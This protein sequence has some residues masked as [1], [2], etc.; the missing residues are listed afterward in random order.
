VHEARMPHLDDQS[1]PTYVR[2]LTVG[3]VRRPVA[4]KTSARILTSASAVWGLRPR[5]EPRD[6]GQALHRRP[7]PGWHTCGGFPETPGPS[8]TDKATPSTCL[9]RPRV[10]PCQRIGDWDAFHASPAISGTLDAIW[11]AVFPVGWDWRVWD[12]AATGRR[13]WRAIVDYAHGSDLR[14]RLDEVTTILVTD[15]DD[16]EC[17][18]TL[19]IN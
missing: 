12:V 15:C 13:N 5:S 2:H 10:R 4:D 16:A 3:L 18:A 17:P 9:R 14:R 11:R 6:E 19:S 7:D 8:G 1:R